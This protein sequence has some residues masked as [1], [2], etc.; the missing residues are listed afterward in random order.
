MTELNLIGN[1]SPVHRRSAHALRQS[2]RFG[3][4]FEVSKTPFG[5]DKTNDESARPDYRG[6]D[7]VQ[8]RHSSVN[9]AAEI[10]KALLVRNCVRSSFRFNID[11]GGLHGCDL[12][13]GCKRRTRAPGRI[14]QAKDGGREK[15]TR[16]STHLLA[17]AK[18]LFT[19]NKS[20]G[21]TC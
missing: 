17:P 10:P 5:R 9:V 8:E 3:L 11:R 15:I 14:Q 12:T 1:A 19:A 16:I 21:N 18:T 6:S 13:T 2:R 7:H 4:P 20:G